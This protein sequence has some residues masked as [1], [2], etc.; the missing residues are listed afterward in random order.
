MYKA[1]LKRERLPKHVRH[2]VSYE[3]V[4][5]DVLLFDVVE[6][7][8]SKGGDPEA[9]ARRVERHIDS[10]QKNRRFT[11]RDLDVE[12]QR[13]GLRDMLCN[14]RAECRGLRR[15]SGEELL[16]RLGLYFLLCDGVQ[17][18]CETAEVLHLL[19]VNMGNGNFG[20]LLIIGTYVSSADILV[21][22]DIEV[23]DLQELTAF[24][25]DVSDQ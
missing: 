10:L 25:G 21:T 20:M 11:P 1:L 17:D 8:V 19:H 3:L 5:A 15:G 7:E 4:Q 18:G 14:G 2:K 13:L 24:L 22:F 12:G 6:E 23:D 16:D 9:H